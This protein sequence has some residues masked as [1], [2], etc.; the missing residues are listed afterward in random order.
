MIAS[1]MCHLVREPGPFFF[2]V[3]TII[4]GY[5]AMTLFFR[6]VGCLCPDF[7]VAIRLAATIITLLVLTSGYLIQWQSEQVWLRWFFYIN[8]LGLGFSALMIN[9]FRHL[10]LT[11]EGYVVSFDQIY[12]LS[13]DCIFHCRTSLVPSGPGYGDLTHQSCTLPGSV[14]GQAVVS[15]SD[16]IQIAFSYAKAE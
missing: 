7:D 13:T 8:S 12:H 5:L 9:E 6:T 11:C 4:F 10:D 16:Y 1:F 15:G 2:F 3:I 14:P